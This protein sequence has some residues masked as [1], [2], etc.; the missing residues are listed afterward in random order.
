MDPVELRGETNL[1]E[2]GIASLDPKAED[3]DLTNMQDIDIGKKA[4]VVL[5][6]LLDVPG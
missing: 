6:T 4:D 3:V 5:A 2:L 1:E